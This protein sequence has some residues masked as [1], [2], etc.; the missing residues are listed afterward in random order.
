MANDK[1]LFAVLTF[2]VLGISIAGAQRGE[3]VFVRPQASQAVKFSAPWRPNGVSGETRVVGTVIDIR[4]VPVAYATVQL[5]DLKTGLVLKTG[6]TSDLGEYQF[7]L[8][9]PGTYVVEMV[10]VDNHVIALSNAGSLARYETLNTVI[11][12]PGI[13][14][15][16]S[17][18]MQAVVD[19]SG[20]FGMGSANT[21]TASTLS[22]AIDTQIRPLDPG[23]SVSPQ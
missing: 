13:W 21:M 15:Y 16:G 9:E 23:E 18:S 22:L 4:Q 5:R 12:L 3:S 7:D 8:V 14:N 19:R 11:Q 20:F 17:R 10:L 2:A 1:K 6:Q